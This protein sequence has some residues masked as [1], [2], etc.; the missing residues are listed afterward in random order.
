M[1]LN[2]KKKKTIFFF[3][4]LCAVI[5]IM[6]VAS[7]LVQGLKK[8]IQEQNNKH[9]KYVFQNLKATS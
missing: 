5:I 2:V 8:N 9:T 6:A 3:W 1:W 4:R 7:L